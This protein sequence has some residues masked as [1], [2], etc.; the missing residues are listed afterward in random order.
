MSRVYGMAGGGW[1]IGWGRR[2]GW[3]RSIGEE[4]VICRWEVNGGCGSCGGAWPHLV[5][6][7]VVMVVR[8]QLARA[9]HHT[10]L[11]KQQRACMK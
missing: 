10:H 4:G 6:V 7:V 11:Y 1:R 2:R 8:I 9:T 5:V 3:R